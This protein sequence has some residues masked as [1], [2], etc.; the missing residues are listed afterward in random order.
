[1]HH[2]HEPARIGDM[3]DRREIAQR[4]VGKLAVDRGIDGVRARRDQ[5]RIAV[6]N[7]ARDELGADDVVCAGAIVDSFWPTMRPTTSTAPPGATGTTSLTGRSGYAAALAPAQ[8]INAKK[9]KPIAIENKE[10]G[11]ASA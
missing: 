4:V 3:A 7:R 1:M 11:T 9:I 10:Q 2:D 6:G 5:Q 8:N